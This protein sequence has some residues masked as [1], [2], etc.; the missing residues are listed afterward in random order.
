[1]NADKAHPGMNFSMENPTKG[2]IRKDIDTVWQRLYQCVVTISPKAKTP[3]RLEQGLLDA[4]R[5]IRAKDGIS[6]TTQN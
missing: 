1:L 3:L 4:L 2:K 6:V 5:E